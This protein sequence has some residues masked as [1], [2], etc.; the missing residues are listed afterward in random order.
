LTVR[1]RQRCSFEMGTARCGHITLQ[2]PH[3]SLTLRGSGWRSGRLE[4]RLGGLNSKI[5]TQDN[6]LYTIDL[7]SLTLIFN[8][9]YS[10]LV[11]HTESVMLRQRFVPML[12]EMGLRWSIYSRS[13]L[14][15]TML[16]MRTPPSH[17]AV[18]IF[19][20]SLP[21]SWPFPCGIPKLLEM[22]ENFRALGGLLS[23]LLLLLWRLA[24]SSLVFE[25]RV[26]L[27][28]IG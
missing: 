4:L 28:H 6:H 3:R 17:D 13:T 5:S 1:C 20:K 2:L 21:N 8:F 25:L 7:G 23:L 27:G 24:F 26:G 11:V 16:A 10:I 15:K 14:I 12:L 19:V 9:G 18:G 22:Q